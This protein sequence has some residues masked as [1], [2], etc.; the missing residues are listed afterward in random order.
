MDQSLIEIRKSGRQL[1]GAGKRKMDRR[2][3]AMSKD[4][5]IS[6]IIPNF[7][8]ARQFHSALGSV[9]AQTYRNFEVE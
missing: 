8:R 9:L 5:F 4:P 3:H 2:Y 7:N 1:L 6:V